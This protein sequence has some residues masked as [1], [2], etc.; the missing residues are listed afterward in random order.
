MKDKTLISYIIPAYQAETFIYNKLTLF[1]RYCE[2]TDLKSEIIVVNDGSTDR[3]DEVIKTFLNDNKGNQIFKYIN[4]PENRGKGAAVKK[5]FEQSEGQYIVFT[6]CDLPYKFKDIKSVVNNLM[7]SSANIVIAC[8]M[9][10][11]SVYHIRSENLSYIYIRHTSGRVY[12]W[13]INFFT[14]LNISD[15]QAGLKGF[16]RDTADLILRKMTIEGFSFDVDLLTCA[17]ENEKS[18]VTVPIEFNYDSEMSSINFI[19]QTFVMTFGLFRV[20][21]KK[22]LGDYRK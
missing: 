5:G 16:D 14:G 19:K 6:D 18:I 7:H 2:N 3:T 15:T 4:L 22:I 1:S 8:R 20:F 10:K 21:L 13:I 9:H 17:K 11:D 12:N